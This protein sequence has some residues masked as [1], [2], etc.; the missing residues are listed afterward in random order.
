MVSYLASWLHDKP[1]SKSDS[2]SFTQSFGA[3]IH[4]FPACICI[5]KDNGK[6]KVF[7]GLN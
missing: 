7:S 6:C 4:V 3:Q 2:E 1:V 5:V